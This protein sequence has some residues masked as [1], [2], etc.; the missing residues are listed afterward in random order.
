[1]DDEQCEHIVNLLQHYELLPWQACQYRVD[2]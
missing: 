1:M 2:Y